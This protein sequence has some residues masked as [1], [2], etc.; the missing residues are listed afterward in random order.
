M[1]RNAP[2]RHALS[3]HYKSSCS[4]I[5]LLLHSFVVPVVPFTAAPAILPTPMARLSPFRLPPLTTTTG[6]DSNDAA[7][8][9]QQK[10][11][12]LRRAVTKFQAR[13]VTYLIIPCVAA[14]VGWFTNWLAVQMI[15]YPIHYKGLPLIVK[16]EV[17]LGFLG[18]Q[19]IIPCKTVTMTTTMVDM[20]TTQLLH[21][22]SVFARLDPS[23][24]AKRLAPEIPKLTQEVIQDMVPVSWL[25]SLP[26]AVAR[27][28]DTATR[29]VLQSYNVRFCRDLTQAIQ[30]NA[31]SL[32]N[33]QQCVVTQM[34]ADRS[35]LG[36]LFQIC[37]RAEL[38]FLTN[39]GLW[40][41]FLLGL[42]QMA[43]ALVY[44]NPWSLSIGGG[45]VGLATN[46]LALKWI[47]EPV[48]PTRVGPFVLQGQFL[49]RQAAVAKEFSEYFSTSVLSSPQIF[50]S[51]L[52]DPT[53]APV[54]KT[55]FTE[56]F[57]PYA[58]KIARGLQIA[59]EPETL[60]ALTDRVLAKLPDHLPVIFP[61]V[62]QT[63]RLQE[64]LE[65]SMKAM[66]SAQFERV[67]HPIFEQDELTLILAGMVLGFLA[68]LVQQG[69]ETGA[70][71][72]PSFASVRQRVGALVQRCRK[73]FHRKRRSS[74]EGEADP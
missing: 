26:T 64:T 40:F 25:A 4:V 24:V 73:L 12:I 61:Y 10:P 70:I 3:F 17:P 69:L 39:S 63:L 31:E 58:T 52:S 67:L 1:V 44:D 13:P 38:L 60:A 74:E 42:I 62:D 36:E 47:F 22:P 59:L 27:G 72:L 54:F 14:V 29:Q 50:Q 35:K 57:T 11:S 21:I 2:R 8:P 7:S 71:Q 45:I 41:G 32:F 23:Q 9:Q 16:P 66:T 37:G 6:D 51:I 34:L 48:N 18:W 28:W 30:A 33:I 19:G 49:R 5:L 56:H 55:L 65:T 15:F 53:T 20:V 46:W 68:G 43:V